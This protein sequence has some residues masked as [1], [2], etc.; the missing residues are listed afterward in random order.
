MYLLYWKS[1]ALPELKNP[2]FV[3]HPKR[4]L[5]PGGQE[6]LPLPVQPKELLL[7]ATYGDPIPQPLSNAPR[8]D[9]VRRDARQVPQRICGGKVLFDEFTW[10][11]GRAFRQSG[12]CGL[13]GLGASTGANW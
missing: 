4:L 12:G 2:G 6:V 10:D 8:K 11:V 9:P 3:K 13:V 1:A 5:T 7:L